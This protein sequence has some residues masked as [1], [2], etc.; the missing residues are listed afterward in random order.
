MLI[1]LDQITQP[2]IDISLDYML[3][4]SGTPYIWGGTN[5]AGFDCSGYVIEYLRALGVVDSK[6]D[7]SALGIYNKFKG[8]ATSEKKRGFLVFYGDSFNTIDHVEIMLTDR[9][10][11][12][13][14]GGDRSTLSTSIALKKNA[15]VRV[16][17]ISRMNN[18]AYVRV[19][20]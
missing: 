17:P 1:Q 14:S 16:R 19:G 8:Y 3:T 10:A 9:L 12:G 6:Y 2:E 13:A 11:L 18:V 7:D 4:F 20:L 15:F 5:P